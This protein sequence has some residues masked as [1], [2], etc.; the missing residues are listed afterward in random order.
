MSSLP[1]SIFFVIIAYNVKNQG[2]SQNQKLASLDILRSLDLFD[3]IQKQM[4]YI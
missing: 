2:C 1:I 3:I 4:K